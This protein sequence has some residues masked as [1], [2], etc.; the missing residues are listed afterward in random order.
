MTTLTLK[1]P[2]T[3]DGE[4]GALAH[5]QGMSKS[6]LVRKAVSA[7]LSREHKPRKGSFLTQAEDLAGCVEGPEDLSCHERHLDG[8]GQ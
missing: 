7:L 8:Y 6:A 5:R 1:I 4:L 2:E 3:M